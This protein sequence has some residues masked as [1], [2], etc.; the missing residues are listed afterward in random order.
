M[1]P[2]R[3][4][5][6]NRTASAGPIYLPPDINSGDILSNL[7]PL[8]NPGLPHSSGVFCFSLWD[9]LIRQTEQHRQKYDKLLKDFGPRDRY[10]GS[11]KTISSLPVWVIPGNGNPAGPLNPPPDIRSGAILSNNLPFGKP[12]TAPQSGVFIL[13]GQEH[14]PRTH[15]SIP[16]YWHEPFRFIT[17][18]LK[19]RH[20]QVPH[21]GLR[22]RNGLKKT[23]QKEERH[24]SSVPIECKS[25][26][27]NDLSVEFWLQITRHSTRL[28]PPPSITSHTIVTHLSPWE[29]PGCPYSLGVFI[30]PGQKKVPGSKTGDMK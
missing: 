23:R 2:G 18:V 14:I 1:H 9:R 5:P 11:V 3:G 27:L 26:F 10:N 16:G 30:L 15:R 22:S 17:V 24:L 12:R 28:S 6:V 25:S 19:P 8:G 13:S 20:G 29:T 4:D 7:P 21:H